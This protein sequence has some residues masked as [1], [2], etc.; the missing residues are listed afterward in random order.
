[1]ADQVRRLRNH[2]EAVVTRGND[3]VV[4][5]RRIHQRVLVFQINEI[6]SDVLAELHE[7]RAKEFHDRRRDHRIFL[8]QQ[9]LQRGHLNLFSNPDSVEGY[10]IINQI[11]YIGKLFQSFMGTGTQ[12]IRFE[13]R[14]QPDSLDGYRLETKTEGG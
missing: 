9:L 3:E 7:R 5:R 8:A 1:M 14:P 11:A 13:K 6:E 10:T 12:M 2:G 4:K